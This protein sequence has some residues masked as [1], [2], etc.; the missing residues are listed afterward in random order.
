MTQQKRLGRGLAAL[1]GDDFNEETVVQDARAL[2]HVPIEFL[3]RNP[4][5]P[6]KE[7][8][9]GDL[10]DLATSIREKGLLQ[11]IIVRQIDNGSESQ[12]DGYE[13]VA[14]ERRWRASQQAGIHEVPVIIRNVSDG[15]AFEIALI[16][17]IQRADLD[18]VEE[19]MGYRQLMDRFDYTQEQMAGTLG[20]S[21][22]HIANSM[23]LLKLP[24]GIQDK[25]RSGELTA[26]HARALINADDPEE[27]A[28]QIL[29]LGLNVRE[30]EQ[31]MRK[32]VLKPKKKTTAEK[33]PNVLALER[34]L[35]SV[36]GLKVD[37]TSSGETGQLR[38]S[39]TNLEQLDDVCKRLSNSG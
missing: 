25:L 32:G 7:F 30:T 3:R 29:K 17:N 13:I 21:R 24:E 34:E 8:D 28:R 14:G 12:E 15:E 33:D 10:K 1:I 35:S 4:N 37:I 22:S 38:I 16:E 6:R 23:R 20:K 26:G 27:M 19:A 31:L 2:R 9:E 39:Y 11:P 5:N 36:L 18:P